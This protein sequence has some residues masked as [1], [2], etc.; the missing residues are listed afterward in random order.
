MCTNSANIVTGKTAVT[1]TPAK[2]TYHQSTYQV[3]MRSKGEATKD[4]VLLKNVCDKT[5][6]VMSIKSYV[7]F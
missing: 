1:L 7:S 4:Q 6:K 5:V 2:T 3:F